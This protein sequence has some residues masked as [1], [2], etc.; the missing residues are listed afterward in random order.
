MVKV[1]INI[2]KLISKKGKVI[3]ISGDNLI[4][5]QRI[6]TSELLNNVFEMHG[7]KIKERFKDKIKN[8]TL[9]PSRLGHKGLIKNEI[10]SVFEYDE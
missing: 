10:I 8:R 7:F 4:N 6:P 9:P 3:I 5:N 1:I 2:K